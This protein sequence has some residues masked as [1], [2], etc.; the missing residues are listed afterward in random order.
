M[1]QSIKNTLFNHKIL[2]EPILRKIVQILLCSLEWIFSICYIFFIINKQL[3]NYTVGGAQNSTVQVLKSETGGRWS[4]KI[5]FDCCTFVKS[6][7]TNGQIFSCSVDKQCVSMETLYIRTLHT[8]QAHCH[9]PTF[10]C[11]YGIYYMCT[12]ICDLYIYICYC[13]Y[14]LYVCI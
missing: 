1:Y 7:R 2:E 10:I 9:P 11:C 14:N 4:L 5:Y 8:S 13:I 6:S 12:Y 3:L